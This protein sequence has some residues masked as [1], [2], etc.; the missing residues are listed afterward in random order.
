MYTHTHVQIHTD[1][2]EF[3][4]TAL[5]AVAGKGSIYLYVCVYIYNTYIYMY[6]HAHMYKYIPPQVSLCAPLHR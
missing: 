2:G 5:S 1:A 3:V 4:C 6:A